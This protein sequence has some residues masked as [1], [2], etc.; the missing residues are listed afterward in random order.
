M[1]RDNRIMHLS[2]TSDH[3][4]IHSYFQVV[5]WCQLICQILRQN[6][7]PACHYFGMSPILGDSGCL[8]VK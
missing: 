4:G 2:S 3:H 5:P 1:R 6:K 7:T 8:S